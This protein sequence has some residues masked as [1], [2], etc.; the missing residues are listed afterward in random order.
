MVIGLTPN[1]YYTCVMLAALKCASNNNN[2]THDDNVLKIN[3][4]GQVAEYCYSKWQNLFMSFDNNIIKGAP[5]F[6]LP[7][8]HSV[9]IK[10]STLVDANLLVDPDKVHA[11]VYHLAIVGKFKV[12]FVGYCFSEELSYLGFKNKKGQELFGCLKSNLK[13]YEDD[14]Y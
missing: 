8:G 6:I 12:E 1:E 11:D 14:N 9:D 2:G 5:D 10:A 13:R 4:T 7:C 3:I